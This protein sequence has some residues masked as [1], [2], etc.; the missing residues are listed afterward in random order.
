M[1]EDISLYHQLYLI[2]LYNKKYPDYFYQHRCLARWFSNTFN[3]SYSEAE[4]MDFDSL[5]LHKL[6]YETQDLS[7]KKIDT[8][9]RKEF[10]TKKIDTQT[11][12]VVQK[13]DEA[14]QQQVA[15]KAFEQK[16]K[17]LA[18]AEAEGLPE[19]IVL[20]PDIKKTF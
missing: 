12:E 8:I 16:E 13:E 20:H 1:N 18:K 6:E 7:P 15:Q 17:E 11:E 4:R 19:G 9:F 2:A 10:I 5:L 3:T 14:W